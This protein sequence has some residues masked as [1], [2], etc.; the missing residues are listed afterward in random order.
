MKL[1]F[2]D[3]DGVINSSK[4]IRTLNIVDEIYFWD[5]EAVARLNV[6]IEKS[7]AKL[8][9]SSSWRV[10]RTLNQLKQL[11]NN[12][13]GIKGPIIGK[14]PILTGDRGREI[15][16]WLKSCKKKIH[17]FIIIDDG[18]DME[19]HMDRLVKT[20]FCTGLLDQHINLALNMLNGPVAE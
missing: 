4:Y 20:S 2:L 7:K 17:S 19:P 18:S 15:D 9:I 8:V 6:I 5:P 11:L 3:I 13:A 14:T 16:A 12:N 1:I 10:G